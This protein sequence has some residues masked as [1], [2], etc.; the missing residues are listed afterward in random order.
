MTN[1][2]R[3]AIFLALSSSMLLAC[4]DS[5]G[6]GGGKAGAALG[7]SVSATDAT[8]VEGKLPAATDQSF[9]LVPA[10]TDTFS[11]GT[12][13]LVAFDVPDASKVDAVLLQFG[14]DGYLEVNS[15]EVPDAGTPTSLSFSLDVAFDACASL[16]RKAYDVELRYAVRLLDRSIGKHGATTVTLDCSSAL[17]AKDCSAPSGSGHSANTGH[18]A[19][20]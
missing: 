9:T 10:S 6:G 16:C 2:S 14:G 3:A 4:G 17:E 19:D 20:G 7:Q 13:S 12:T 8:L 5:G 15:F 18:G 1:T 11:P